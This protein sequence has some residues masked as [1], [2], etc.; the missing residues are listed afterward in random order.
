MRDQE[1][2]GV[3]GSTSGDCHGRCLRAELQIHV[4]HIVSVSEAACCFGVRV[5]SAVQHRRRTRRWRC[6]HGRRHSGD[7]SSRSPVVG[8][9]SRPGAGGVSRE[10]WGKAP[11]ASDF[12]SPL[13]VPPAVLTLRRRGWQD[14]VSRTCRVPCLT[15]AKDVTGPDPMFRVKLR[16]CT[17]C[18]SRLPRQMGSTPGPVH[19]HGRYS[20][21]AKHNSSRRQHR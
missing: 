3:G 10:T 15:S 7:S 12:A 14:H 5:Q 16:V 18:R 21:L 8:S 4:K 20:Q 13:S 2:A 1:I 6:A 11:P 9:G 17:G 19:R